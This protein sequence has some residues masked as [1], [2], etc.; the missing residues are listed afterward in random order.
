MSQYMSKT[1]FPF[2]LQNIHRY[3]RHAILFTLNIISVKFGYLVIVNLKFAN[4]S[5]WRMPVCVLG[6]VLL[7]HQIYIAP[8]FSV[9]SLEYLRHVGSTSYRIPFDVGNG[10]L[11]C[12]YRLHPYHA[13]YHVLNFS[14]GEHWFCSARLER[15]SPNAKYSEGTVIQITFW[16]SM[17]EDTALAFLAVTIFFFEPF[18]AVDS[19]DIEETDQI[20]PCLLAFCVLSY[21]TV[22]HHQKRSGIE[23]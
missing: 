7:H 11:C 16:L 3:D 14:W 20:V 5:W 2:M 22:L 10:K 23:R 13:S 8:I 9:F 19:S 18:W 6:M 21:L 4:I 1:C 17:G 15:E 12:G